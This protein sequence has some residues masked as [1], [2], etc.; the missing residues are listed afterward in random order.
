MQHGSNGGVPLDNKRKTRVTRPRLAANSDGVIS[1]A[2]TALDNGASKSSSSELLSPEKLAAIVDCIN[3]IDSLHRALSLASA[4][5]AARSPDK[6][7]HGPHLVRLIAKTQVYLSP[8]S[9]SQMAAYMAVPFDDRFAQ[10]FEQMLSLIYRQDTQIAEL[11]QI[12]S[13]LI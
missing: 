12:V 8:S 13:D 3:D 4:I 6:D 2:A 1:I 11:R 9:S 7:E 10:C 5:L